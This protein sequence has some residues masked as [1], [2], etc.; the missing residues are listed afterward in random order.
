MVGLY[1]LLN[2]LSILFLFIYILKIKN[3]HILHK[4]EYMKKKIIIIS[5]VIGVM[6]IGLRFHVMAK[7]E[8]KVLD[9]VTIVLDAGHGGKDNGAM[10]EG[11]HE[12][13]IN[14]SIV[15][16]TKKA[17]EKKGANVVLTRNGSYDLASPNAKNRKREDMKKRMEIINQENTDLFISV[18]LNSYPNTNVQGAQV[19][20]QKGNSASESFAKL[21]Q[22]R[23]RKEA[24]SKM[25]IKTGAYYLLNNTHKVGALVECGFLTNLHDRELL[26][27][28]KYQMKIASILCNSVVDFFEILE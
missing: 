9:G 25:S 10:V 4:G 8:A 6:C 23:L 11:I 7:R 14:L 17:L 27:Q 15:E 26:V 3:Y 28:E 24:D 2:N 5:F 12:Q 16:K 1:E 18:H 19:F 21:I 13:E 20:Y 22:N